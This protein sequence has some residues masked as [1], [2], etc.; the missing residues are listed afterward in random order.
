MTELFLFL[1]VGLVFLIVL[2]LWSRRSPGVVAARRELPDVE[3]ALEAAQVELPPRALVVRIFSAQDWGFVSSQAP[4]P[5]RRTFLRERRDLA[6]SWLHQTRTQIRQLM[7]LHV[8]AAR[9]SARLSPA[10]EVR[11]ASQYVLFLLTC[12][13]L[14]YLIWLRGPFFVQG[15]AGYASRVAEQLSYLSGSLLVNLDPAL[16]RQIR[17]DWPGGSEGA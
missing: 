8:R 12:D 11:L 15:A 7:K 14:R 1:G 10:S 17:A 6:L 9:G 13:L 16:V 2:L 4:P 3:Q 5:V